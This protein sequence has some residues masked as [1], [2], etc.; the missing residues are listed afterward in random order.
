MDCP[1]YIERKNQ[2]GSKIST[3]LWCS[4]FPF[5]P[6]HQWPQVLNLDAQCHSHAGYISPDGS[7][8]RHAT[9]IVRPHQER[10]QQFIHDPDE[11]FGQGMRCIH[12][13]PPG[14]LLAQRVQQ[15]GHKLLR[16]LRLLR[17]QGKNRTAGVRLSTWDSYGAEGVWTKG[18]QH[19]ICL[20][21]AQKSLLGQHLNQEICACSDFRRRGKQA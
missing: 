5:F 12:F 6:H 2:R 7:I 8:L 1:W 3:R 11:H 20:H 21:F 14:W 18:A 9:R 15:E 10:W 17:R 19:E 4:L 16:H 13:C